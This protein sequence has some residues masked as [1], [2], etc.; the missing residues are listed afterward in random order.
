MKE[1]DQNA[2]ERAKAPDPPDTPA[3]PPGIEQEPVS[4]RSQGVSIQRVAPD[5]EFS[6]LRIG[7]EMFFV[8]MGEE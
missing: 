8:Y 3:E 1:R 2:P 6:L 7:D 4:A 5:Y